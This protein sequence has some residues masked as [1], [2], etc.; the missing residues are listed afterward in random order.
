MF[1]CGGMSGINYSHKIEADI[2]DI[3][4]NH[5]LYGNFIG[6]QY[7][8]D[9]TL[10]AKILKR[11]WEFLVA[12][13][14]PLRSSYN[15]KDKS[16]RPFYGD[17]FQ[18]SETELQLFEYLK[19]KNL[20]QG[21]KRFIHE[22][23]RRLVRE[24]QSALAYLR[25][26]NFQDKGCV[27]G[28]SVN[29]LITDAAG[30]Q[31]ITC[32]LCDIYNALARGQSIPDSKLVARLPEFVFGKQT[33]W[34]E[35]KKELKRQSLK[36]PISMRGL[37]GYFV[38]LLVNW[39]MEKITSQ[40]RLH[41]SLTADQVKALKTKV[42][43]ESGE[44]WISTNVALCAHFCAIMIELVNG[45]KVDKPIRIGQL[46]DLR[47][48]YFPAPDG[49]Q[50][51][52]VG[53][54]ILIHSERVELTDHSRANLA[55]FFKQMTGKFTAAF[56]KDRMDVIAD[57]LRH[58]RNYP[59]LEMVDPLLAVNNQTK[60]PFYAIEFL[61][62]KPIHIIPQ[63]V[64]DTLMFFPTSDGGV[65]IYIRDLFHPKRQAQL[66]TPKWQ[67]RLYDF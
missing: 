48:R 31:K 67:A 53:N 15:K 11:A 40:A 54:A 46:L 29:H 65:D 38:R 41:L 3:D 24:G 42:L 9:I 21:R 47:N 25:L 45:A 30:L 28:L 17:T 37:Q 49:E 55:R 63:D 59:G 57:C 2:S 5:M 66:E 58:G 8:F 6:L 56:V 52:F 61:G 62:H 4:I 44:D 34:P 50:G 20:D 39:S 19:S 60:I 13:F 1:N 22:P 16:F 27:I 43:G 7:V 33:N 51:H 12:E 14:M 18:A 26:T 64:G 36:T 23:S 32:N 35:T 10:D